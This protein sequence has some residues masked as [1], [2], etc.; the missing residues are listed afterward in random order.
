MPR[1][2]PLI[3][4][5]EKSSTGTFLVSDIQLDFYNEKRM[6]K[7]LSGAAF[8]KMGN[9]LARKVYVNIYKEAKKTKTEADLFRVEDLRRLAS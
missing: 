1:N 6:Q 3:I 5:G 2:M 7:M 8:R 9:T 4:K